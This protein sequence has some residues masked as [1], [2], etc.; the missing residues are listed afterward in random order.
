MKVP[1]APPFPCGSSAAAAACSRPALPVW[2]P[3]LPRLVPP[4]AKGIV[5]GRGQ[6]S[7]GEFSP[8]ACSGVTP[9]T[10]APR[11]FIVCAMKIRHAV[12]SNRY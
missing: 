3:I 6:P 5:P 11:C 12:V 4:A 8:A 1:T 9:Q 10:P 2:G 7:Q